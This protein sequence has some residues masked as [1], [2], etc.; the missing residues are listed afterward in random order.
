MT[1][2]PKGKIIAKCWTWSRSR[3]IVRR[4][5]LHFRQQGR[6][7][8]PSSSSSL[9][10]VFCPPT[11]CL[12]TSWQSVWGTENLSEAEL[13]GQLQR[14]AYL[15]LASFTRSNA[16]TPWPYLHSPNCGYE[17]HI[18]FSKKPLGTLRKSCWSSCKAAVGKK[19][20][21]E[22]EFLEKVDFSPSSASAQLRLLFSFIYILIV[23]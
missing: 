22:G 5:S 17:I 18:I 11:R 19:A 7:R 2:K 23:L 3:L 20:I 10:S 9:S 4:G 6:R 1:K 13:L 15:L 14:T 8:T 21:A 16:M 12:T